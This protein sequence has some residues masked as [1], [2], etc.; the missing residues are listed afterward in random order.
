[1]PPQFNS[2]EKLNLIVKTIQYA[3]STSNSGLP[4]IKYM[5]IYQTS[6][7]TDLLKYTRTA[8]PKLRKVPTFKPKG[9]S[10]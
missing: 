6:I 5:L 4:V 8:Q 1:M 9:S 3:I 2:W 7:S 10:G